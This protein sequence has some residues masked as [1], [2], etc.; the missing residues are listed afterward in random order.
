M[1]RVTDRGLGVGARNEG[2]CWVLKVVVDALCQY[3]ALMNGV[4]GGR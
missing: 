1:G 2:D 4:N 3:T